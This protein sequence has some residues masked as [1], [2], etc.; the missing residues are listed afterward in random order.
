MTAPALLWFRNDLRLADNPALAAVADRP[1]LPV[2]VLDDAA[3]GPWAHGG[4]QRWWLHH[5]LARLGADLAALGAP[6][7]CLRGD[8]ATIIPALAEAIGA[9]ETHVARRYE[10]W[11]RRQDEVVAMALAALGRRLVRHRG[12]LLHE[13]EAVKTGTGGY[14]QVYT[15]F[16]RAVLAAGDPGPALPPPTR[17]QAAPGAPASD[18]L[19]LLPRRDWADGFA[20]PWQPGEAGAARRLEHFIAG[21]LAFYAAQRDLP[22]VSGGTSGLSPH[23]RFGEVSPRQVWQAVAANGV[24][25]TVFLKEI[26][27]REF[28]YHLLFHRPEMPEHPLRPAFAAFP[29]APDARLLRAWQQGRTGYPIVDAGMRQ[30]WQTGWMHNRVRMIAASLLVK[31]LLQ[32]WQAGAAWFW[33]C[34]VDGDL[35]SN[36]ASWQWVAG[37]GADAAPYFRVFNPILQGRT[38]DAAGD[39]VRRWVP[40]LAGLPDA[41]IHAPWEAP[42]ALRRG[43]PAPVIGHAEGRARALAAYAE[44]TA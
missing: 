24:Q 39:Y 26:L 3:A 21:G 28:S 27:W 2:F 40:E 16:A 30:L 34:L 6:L 4:A 11:G 43:Y 29:W 17:L 9:A 33:D 41:L 25:A 8:A 38:F 22:G 7:V 23:L 5:S 42:A 31:H 14:Y 32:P 1:I 19:A 12:S 18:D 37:C 13:P 44:V 35:A 10:P 15:P 20:G 36:S